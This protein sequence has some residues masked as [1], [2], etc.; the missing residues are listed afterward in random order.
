M[1][2][3]GIGHRSSGSAFRLYVRSSYVAIELCFIFITVYISLYKQHTPSL[4]IFYIDLIEVVDVGDYVQDHQDRPARCFWRSFFCIFYP[5]D[6][7]CIHFLFSSA[8]KQGKKP[9]IG[10]FPTSFQFIVLQLIITT[11]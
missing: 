9:L 5:G 11:L 10:S 2:V 3:V 1:V 8:S 4:G 7:D 6:S